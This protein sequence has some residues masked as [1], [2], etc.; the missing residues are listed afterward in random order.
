[1]IDEAGNTIW[2]EQCGEEE[3][4]VILDEGVFC[5]ECA[6]FQDEK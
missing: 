1:M 2:C 5:K 3:A 4:T 6:E